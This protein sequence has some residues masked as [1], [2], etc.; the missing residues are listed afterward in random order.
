MATLALSFAV[1]RL[2][3]CPLDNIAGTLV[4]LIDCVLD[5]IAGTLVLNTI[6][7]YIGESL[8]RVIFYTLN[9]LS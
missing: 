4:F 8:H 1:H 2:I 7:K 9:V 3:D 6:N 5:N